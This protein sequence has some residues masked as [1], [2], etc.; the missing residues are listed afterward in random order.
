M[1][2]FL[3][4]EH[5]NSLSIL[6]IWCNFWL[7]PIQNLKI[8]PKAKTILVS[9]K[10]GSRP[11]K[12]A[13]RTGW[14]SYKADNLWKVVHIKGLSWWQQGEGQGDYSGRL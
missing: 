14:C 10:S 1:N 5:I 4:A 8:G 7:F 9:F 13:E 11:L 2:W 12:G 6:W 3:N